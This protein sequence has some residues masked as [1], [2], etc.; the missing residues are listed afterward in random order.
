M[1][2]EPI[3]KI[4]KLWKSFF[5][6]DQVVNALTGADLEINEG[7]FIVV[8]GP[9]GSGK[10][11]LLSALAGLD[12]PTEGNV[13][14]NGVDIYEL[15]SND[16]ARYRRNKIGMVFQQFNL[17]PTLSAL[18]NV[19]MPLILSGISRR[20]AY[21]RSEQLLET[22]GMSDRKNHKPTELSGGQQ[23]R[24]AI[25]RAMSAN[26]S[27][28]FVDEPTGNLDI[29][30]GNEIMQ[31]LKDVNQK[32]GRTIVLVTHNPDFLRF[33]H[34]VIHM[35]DGHVI[36]ETRNDR[37]LGGADESNL[38][39]YCGKKNSCLKFNEII[40][41]SGIHFFS[42][43]LR[44]FLTVL[45]VALGVGS[46]VTLVSIGVG[47]QKITS[48]QLASLDALVAINVSVN[49]D[50]SNKL[51]D[52][53]VAKLK[54]LENVVLVSPSI[55][56]PAKATYAGS[57]SQI[58]LE[59]MN[60][61]ALSF[62]GVYVNNGKSEIGDDG[63]IISRA[64]AKNLDV[65]DLNSMLGQSIKIDMLLIPD[66]SL[67]LSKYENITLDKKIVGI[68]NDETLSTAFLSLNEVRALTKS[69]K[70]NSIKVR[71]SDRKKVAFVRDEIEG[72]GFTTTSV[73]DLINQVDKVFLI[74][75]IVLGIIGGVALVVALIGIVNIM[76]ISLL[77]R[78]HEVGIMKAIG[79]TNSDIKKIFEY[80]VILFGLF[81]AL[82]GVGGAWFF[83]SSINFIVSALMRASNIP[84]KIEVFVT[85]AFFAFEVIFL[86]VVVSLLAGLYPAR[87]ASKLSPM[88]ALRYE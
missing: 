30:T 15:K 41:I 75:Q 54:K 80:E 32:W 18:D 19:A 62:E 82:A 67:D 45:G 48:N 74:G 70:Y 24:V 2:A 13:Y 21:L 9:S 23:Q 66:D 60:S 86:T 59:G 17:I 72:L 79:A 11:T 4:S 61:N 39:Y 14:I 69:E 57:T 6:G 44:T 63:I 37:H 36:K 85:P 40:R 84:G 68:A 49:K 83:G 81:G 42:K 35:E 28:L 10:T 52:D 53:A 26:P 76:T 64:V 29:P 5:V 25:A 27:I 20:E 51:N 65:S 33:G 22:V 7:E 87:R 1:A 46:I 34:R 55:T 56:T 73:V 71:V 3:I 12:K 16:L 43:R 77:E 58:L 50:S 38:K 47:L 8:F 31:I 88:E 78:T